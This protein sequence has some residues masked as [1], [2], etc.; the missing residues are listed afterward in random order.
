MTARSG[1]NRIAGGAK[2]DRP[3]TGATSR[4]SRGS[5]RPAIIREARR[6]L[7]VEGV[8]ALNVR[9][10]ARAIG[11]SP[12]AP[13][14]HFP[15]RG[16]QLLAAVAIEGFGELN[17]VLTAARRARPEAWIEAVIAR[18]VQFGVEHPNLYRAM[19]HPRLADH[20]AAVAGHSKRRDVIGQTYAELSEIKSASYELIVAPLKTLGEAGFLRAGNPY[21]FGLAVA[22]LA[23]GLVGEFV[24]EGLGQ[25]AGD[26]EPW[27]P[28][29]RKMTEFVTEVL[30]T[31]LL[32][33]QRE[34]SRAR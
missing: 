10:I 18:Y 9:E 3:A 27:S 21:D 17:A 19:F 8:D 14:A 13:Y 20:L 11:A 1:K 24:D 4:E 25:R 30:M 34:A 6:L 32:V 31:G 29:R 23:H 7:E 26:A 12:A 16:D 15:G 33:S 5:L 2:T 28:A 22:A